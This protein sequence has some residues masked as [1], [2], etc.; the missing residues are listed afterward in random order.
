MK[1]TQVLESFPIM[2]MLNTKLDEPIVWKQD[3]Q[4][5]KCECSIDSGAIKLKLVISAITYKKL[6]GLRVGF[7]LWNGT[8]YVEQIGAVPTLKSA[9]IIGAVTNALLDRLNHY[10]WDYVVA[11]AKDGVEVRMKLYTRIVER[12]ARMNSWQ[13]GS[14]VVNGIGI[15]VI[16]K[17]YSCQDIIDNIS[18]VN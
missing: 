5:D 2:E 4:W 18:A 7:L 6:S 11:D 9:K 17:K 10:D 15:A 13:Y 3:N 8:D 16:S 12:I 14:G 1:L